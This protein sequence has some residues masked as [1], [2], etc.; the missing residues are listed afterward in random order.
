[1]K[2]LN[3]FNT[4]PKATEIDVDAYLKRIGL[5]QDDP[6][7][8]YLRKLHFAHIH[9]IPFENLDIHYSQKIQLDYT[10]IFKKIVEKG[11]GGFCYELNG[12]FY[13]L[14]YHLGYECYVTSAQMKTEMGEFDPHFG[15]MMII[16]KL[17]DQ[18]FLV[19]VGF[20]NSFSNPKKI[21]VGTVQ[22]DYTTYWKFE[23]DPDENFLLQ[24]SDN[25]SNFKTKYRFS[26]EEKQ[27]IQFME[28]CVF[29]QTS[30]KSP[31]TQGKII[32]IKTLD[33]RVTLTNKKLQILK[34]S[35]T[36]ESDI[37]NEDEF[38]SKLE[39]Y[40]SISYRQLSALRN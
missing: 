35:E 29:H 24:Y 13:H 1:M 19:D 7:L 6:T 39:Q 37:L 17:E 34:L 23:T 26:L 22:M 27:I 10:E 20:G 5:E 16:V 33:G 25:T 8:A 21:E 11:R 40:F 32:S 18:P 12:L 9:K 14:L 38:L 15:H 28:M 36:S 31:F 4:K 30:E 3:F 2:K